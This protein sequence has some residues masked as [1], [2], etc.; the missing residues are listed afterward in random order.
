LAP[1]NQFT[2]SLIGQEFK[3]DINANNPIGYGGQVAKVFGDLLEHIYS[4]TFSG[5]YAPRNFKSTIGRHG[6]AFAGYQQQDSQEFLAFLLDGLHEDL[7]RIKNKPAT[8]KPELP[9][10]KVN[11]VEAQKQ[12]AKDCWEL[13]KKRNESV[14]LDLFSGLYRSVLVCPS[15]QKV[16]ITFDPFFDLTLP[17]PVDNTWVKVV[18]VVPQ[19]KPPIEYKVVMDGHETIGYMKQYLAGKF[20]MS[21]SLLVPAEKYNGRF[22]TIHDEDDDIVTAKINTRDHVF[23]FEL[24]REVEVAN[25]ENSPFLVPVYHRH[26]TSKNTGNV[27]ARMD[28]GGSYFGEPFFITLT[29]E[30]AKDEELITN[31]IVAG[32]KQ[33]SAQWNELEDGAIPF[34]LNYFEPRFNS[35]HAAIGFAMGGSGIKPFSER[36]P[37]PPKLPQK[38]EE[39]DEASGLEPMSEGFDKE[40]VKENIEVPQQEETPAGSGSGISTPS[41]GENRWAPSSSS[42]NLQPILLSSDE[43]DNNRDN[44]ASNDRVS[45]WMN[46]NEGASE[47][48]SRSETLMQIDDQDN[49]EEEEEETQQ[50]EQGQFVFE[51]EGLVVDWTHDA[52]SEVLGGDSF[53]SPEYIE[54]DDVIELQKQV[55]ERR[56]RGICLSDC[57]DLF[58]KPEV[59]G[60]DDVWYCSRC[61][62]LR[63]ATKTIDIWR[64]PE[65]FTVHLKRFSSFRSFSDKIDDVVQFPIEGL[66]MSDRVGDPEH[67]EEGLIYDLFAVDN[68]FGGLGGG[69]YT[70]CVKNFVNNKWYT[71]DDSRVS[72]T[73]PE[74]AVTGAAYLLFYRRRSSK[75]LGTQEVA[76]FVETMR[77]RNYEPVIDDTTTT[78][79]LSTTPGYDSASSFRGRGNVLGSST[80]SL[81]N[82]SLPWGEPQLNFGRSP[83]YMDSESDDASSTGA[84]ADDKDDSDYVDDDD[85]DEEDEK[86]QES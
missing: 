42:T 79:P 2:N 66:D 20:G 69:H 64:V 81:N 51:N 45:S 76:S 49:E 50:Q 85:L 65:I 60:E 56:R 37:K 13:H 3:K 53:S 41:T 33:M 78:T 25:D 6:S 77:E 31:K 82:G 1:R 44:T 80:S 4:N 70:A 36:K 26:Q 58:S 15:C 38:R 23:V 24:D 59:L 22:Y 30:E 8:E 75:P 17:L 52:I 35:R 48:P 9:D 19:N 46:D 5:S 28:R 72:E 83:A 32:Y 21:K 18:T 61:K 68:H 84:K 12:L 29:P 40:S 62:E 7:N 73:N 47:S 11:D 71:F 86:M 55:E 27:P 63:Q 16:S 10:D 43:E 67:K 39:K 54:N 57:L 34:A 74:N 14:V